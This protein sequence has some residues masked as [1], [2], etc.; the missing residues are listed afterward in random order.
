M[1]QKWYICIR[2]VVATNKNFIQIPTGLET[3]TSLNVG[4]LIMEYWRDIQGFEGFY[5]VSN[6][7]NV[8]RL[9]SY[10]KHPSGCR[11]IV[12]A[13]TLKLCNSNGY[14]LVMITNNNSRTN[15]MVHRLVATAFIPNPKNKAHVNHING[16]KSDNRVENLEW[17]TPSENETHKVHILGKISN[18]T[19]LKNVFKVNEPII[20]DGKHVVG[21]LIQKFYNDL[22]S[23]KSISTQDTSYGRI[24]S[25]KYLLKTK[26]NIAVQSRKTTGKFKEYFLTN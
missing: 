8:K 21:V 2:R 10:T 26:Y 17:N 22:K 25:L 18:P 11:K 3:T 15:K 12:R 6:L 16:I 9:E 14:S 7:G 5:Q 1:L 23:G 19:N 24:Y 20:I 4:F 13:K